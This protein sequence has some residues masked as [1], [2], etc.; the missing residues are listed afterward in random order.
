[1]CF[2]EEE[3]VVDDDDDEEEP[4]ISFSAPC[5]PPGDNGKVFPCHENGWIHEKKKC[6]NFNSNSPQFLPPSVDR[7]LLCCH[8]TIYD[9]LTNGNCIKK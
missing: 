7:R 6:Y 2:T 8:A 4:L 3:V 5:G 1:M 9:V